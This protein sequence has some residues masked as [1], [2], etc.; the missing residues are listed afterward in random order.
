MQCKCKHLNWRSQIKLTQLDCPYLWSPSCERSC[1]LDRCLSDICSLASLQIPIWNNKMTIFVSWY[2]S[3]LVYIL[4]IDLFEGFFCFFH[5]D[6]LEFIEMLKSTTL[7]GTFPNTLR[8]SM[9]FIF[10]KLDKGH[11]VILK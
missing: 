7:M 9:L 11:K 1:T 5:D 2:Q 4:E 10:V 6:T 3:D 8:R